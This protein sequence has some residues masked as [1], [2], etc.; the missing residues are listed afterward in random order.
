MANSLRM[1]VDACRVLAFG[2]I[3]ANYAAVG[4]ALTEPATMIF[5]QNL[6]DELLYFSY[7][8]VTDHFPLTA[9]GQKSLDIAANRDINQDF[10]R[11][12]GTIFYVKRIGVPT[13]GSV[14]IT[15]YHRS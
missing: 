5:F 12:V 1:D 8:G 14:Y 2:G 7:D 11:A 6:T 3:G 10:K 4:G 13:A 9:G 15:V